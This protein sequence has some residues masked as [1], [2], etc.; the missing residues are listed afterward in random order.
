MGFTVRTVKRQGGGHLYLLFNEQ[1]YVPVQL[2]F[3]YMTLTAQNKYSEGTCNVICR[4]LKD[5]YTYYYCIANIDIEAILSSGEML[6][7]DQITGFSRWLQMKRIEPSNIIGIGFIEHNDRILSN[8]T[9]NQY[10]HFIKEFLLW[11][12]LTF[13]P[14]NIYLQ[15]N[16]KTFNDIKNRLEAIFRNLKSKTKKRKH[17]KGLDKIHKKQLLSI[18]D[19]TSPLNPF[20]GEAIRYRN[21]M[22]IKL[23][24]ATGLRRA[25]IL[26]AYSEDIPDLLFGN[27]WKVV[28][29]PNIPQDSRNPIPRVKTCAREIALTEN[30]SM[31]VKIY[32]DK[33]RW[34]TNKKSQAKFIKRKPSHPF[35]IINTQDSRP[36]SLDSINKMLYKLGEV[37]FSDE[38][39]KLHPHILRNTFCNEYL[40]EAIDIRGEDITLAIDNLKRICGWSEKSEMPALYAAKWHQQK[41]DAVNISRLK[42][43]YLDLD[44]L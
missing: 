27:K 34:I 33:Y 31:M 37:A 41:A 35:F 22:I 21:W 16:N 28:K 18:A 25:E 1:P 11:S 3:R 29:R 32:K 26:C 30:E 6:T 2:P 20:K 7:A 13:I 8:D 39:I 23:L 14:E 4:V 24:L 9:F 17:T 15:D 5:I 19:P 10:L 44:D 36:L 40:E 42:R 43:E 38:D 12:S